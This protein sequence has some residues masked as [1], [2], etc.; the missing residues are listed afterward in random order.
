MPIDPHVQYRAVLK[1]KTPGA[2]TDSEYGIVAG[3]SVWDTLYGFTN[4]SLAT[5]RIAFTAVEG[6][7]S[8]FFTRFATAVEYPKTQYAGLERAKRNAA[9]ESTKWLIFPFPIFTADPETTPVFVG[10]QYFVPQNNY[11]AQTK[12]AWTTAAATNR[13]DGLG[14]WIFAINATEYTIPVCEL[15]SEIQAHLLEDINGGVSFS[16]GLWTVTEVLNYLNHR[17]A[18][19]LME[20]GCLQV[21]TTQAAAA[22]ADFY[23]LPTDLID[24][25][26]VSWIRGSMTTVLPRADSL[27]VD[28]AF[29]NWDSVNGTPSVH[30][31]VPEQSLEVR[32]APRASADGTLDLIYVRNVP[33]VTN[34]CSIMPLPDEWVPFVKWGVISDMLAKEGEANDPQRSQWAE[35]RYVEGVA[36]ARLYMGVSG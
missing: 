20:T 23:D 21:H 31:Q 24:L 36:L 8:P 17:I 13:G 1:S 15:L 16:S 4:F 35:Q 29:D 2:G 32:V 7:D 18:R 26:H 10:K 22:A 9:Q 6:V 34:D 28:L 19:F 30:L 25:R 14:A 27:Q 3:P 33:A 11:I 12:A 5:P